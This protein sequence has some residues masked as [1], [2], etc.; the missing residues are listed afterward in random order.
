MSFD[1]NNFENLRFDPFGFDNVLLN[2]T[3]DPDENIFNNLSQI[4][5]VF[6]AVEEAATSFQK[7]ND[8]TFSA[9]HLNVRS[10]IQTFESLK[11]LLTTIKFEF[12]V[13]CLTETWCTD[14]PRN[15]FLFDLDN[16]TSTTQVRKY[17]RGDGIC[18]F[19]HNSLTFKLRSDLG[20]NSNNIESL[21][22]EIINKKS[23][24][25]VI[26][27]QY[28]QPVGDFKQNKTYLENFFNKMKNSSRAI[29]IVHHT[30]LN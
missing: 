15:E 26:S 7:F 18:V 10:L 19:I 12:K 17:G 29:Y 2:N 6:Y 14:D 23:K 11:K 3:S 9:L 8:K 22:I 13:I 4:D 21:V 5:S 1:E 24:N 28:R 20:T 30:N 25:V 16:Y 27:A